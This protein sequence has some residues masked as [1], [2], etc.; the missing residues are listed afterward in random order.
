MCMPEDRDRGDW[1]RS[2][3]FASHIGYKSLLGEGGYRSMGST[4]GTIVDKDDGGKR[5]TKI[6]L[7]GGPCAGK[8]TAS[9]WIVKEFSK[10]GYH[11]MFV[12]ESATEL[13]T[14]GITLDDL[15]VDDFHRMNMTNQLNKE[16]V[17][18][19]AAKAHPSDKILIVCDRGLMDNAA[20]MGR[21]G[22]TRLA[23]SMGHDEILLR[24]RYDAVIHLV[25]AANG[26]EEAY[27]LSNNGAR[28]ETLEQA[29][30]IDAKLI[31][32]WTGHPHLRIVPNDGSFRDKMLRV[33]Q[34][35]ASVLGEPEPME[36]ERKF[37]IGIPSDDW[38][39]SCDSHSTV[40]IIQT[41][42]S[43]EEDGTERRIRQRGRSG[44]YVYT[45]TMKRNV[46]TGDSMTRAEKERT[47]SEQE[48]LTLMME[49]DTGRSQIRK[50][51]HL[52]VTGGRYLEI[53]VYPF[54]SERAIL[55][56]EFPTRDAGVDLPDGL[57]VIREVT[58]DR[59]YR[60]ASLA[61]MR[62]KTLAL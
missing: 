25:T 6:A 42:L 27:T 9:S 50:T 21:E 35:V 19:E 29:R 15:S 48:Y 36:I 53:D 45:L 32:A 55:E 54:D 18:E 2:I 60:N 24:D 47:I 8:T 26:A 14:G 43:C 34:E 28:S 37:L 40:D 20:Y 61:E 1:L 31:E 4:T 49:T 3:G 46:A 39:A 5:I 56:I 51:R 41:Y 44:S 23:A 10:L 33:L 17:F 57:H 62:I 12:P 11:V 38:F 22:F 58:D 59:R 13:I 16:H 30:T 7:T 52:V